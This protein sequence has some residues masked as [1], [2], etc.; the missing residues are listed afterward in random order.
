MTIVRAQR[1][2]TT[3]AARRATETAWP[4]RPG[5]TNPTNRSSVRQVLR[6]RGSPGLR[7]RSCGAAHCMVDVRAAYE[8]G[9]EREIRVDHTRQRKVLP[10]RL[11]APLSVQCSGEANA[12]GHSIQAVYK[13]T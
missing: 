2:P 4:Q 9:V 6:D 7:A 13:K 1:H 10:R 11:D 8:I 3:A 5:A 12:F